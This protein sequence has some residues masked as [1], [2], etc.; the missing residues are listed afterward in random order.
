MS[1]FPSVVW[2]IYNTAIWDYLVTCMMNGI[3]FL[4]IF[5]KEEDYKKYPFV[6][7]SLC[8]L[9]LKTVAYPLE[10]YIGFHWVFAM[11]IPTIFV[12]LQ[13][14]ADVYYLLY[15]KII[16]SGVRW[17]ILKI[18]LFFFTFRGLP[19]FIYFMSYMIYSISWRYIF[20]HLNISFKEQTFFGTWLLIPIP[21]FHL[22]VIVFPIVATWFAIAHRRFKYQE[23]NEQI[24]VTEDEEQDGIRKKFKIWKNDQ[25]VSDIGIITEVNTYLA[26]KENREKT[27]TSAFSIVKNKDGTPY[28]YTKDKKVAFVGLTV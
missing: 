27:Q 28:N 18:I 15:G 19:G 26:L 6:F 16:Q 5:M 8:L 21:V 11:M 7:D 23:E 22:F 20:P 17:K 3:L 1:I 12:G 9:G 13:W 24:S 4:I 14:P 10:N 2:T 25:K